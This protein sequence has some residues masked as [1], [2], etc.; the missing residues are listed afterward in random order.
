MKAAILA[1]CLIAAPAFAEEPWGWDLQ[2]LGKDI[3]VTGLFR[4]SSGAVVIEF[5]SGHG[6]AMEVEF[7]DTAL[8]KTLAPD[9]AREMANDNAVD[10]QVRAGLHLT[11]IPSHLF[12]PVTNSLGTQFGT[13]SP[14]SG[15]CDLP[16]AH[17][18]T[19][20]GKGPTDYLHDYLIVSKLPQPRTQSYGCRYLDAPDPVRLRLRW[21]GQDTMLHWSDGP[22]VYYVLRGIPVVVRFDA[23]GRTHF[24]D[25]HPTLAM[26]RAD[27]I[28]EMTES[29]DTGEME[30]SQ[31]VVDRMEAIIASEVKP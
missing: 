17:F 21:A 23:G 12:D 4:S 25:H 30:P 9:R 18:I 14:S 26:V 19:V 10:A 5:W 3:R 6:A 8:K 31:A 22:N 7:Y 11:E 20:T 13:A 1:L 27:K 2:S 15:K 28:H 29:M 16:Y 24:F